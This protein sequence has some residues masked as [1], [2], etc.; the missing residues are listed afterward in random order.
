MIDNGRSV[1]EVVQSL[2]VGENL[3]YRWRA[4]T[5]KKVELTATVEAKEL[6]SELQLLREKFRQTE[7][8]RE[9]LWKP[10]AFSAALSRVDLPIY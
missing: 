8:E 5:A 3:I 7:L 1:S 2:G 10:C 9:V 4:K 6:L